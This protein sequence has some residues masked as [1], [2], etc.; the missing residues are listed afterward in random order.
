MTCKKV[1]NNNNDSQQMVMKSKNHLNGKKASVFQYS[2][3]EA[4]L[5]NLNPKIK[6][7]EF[8][9]IFYDSTINYNNVIYYDTSGVQVEKIN[10]INSMP[11]FTKGLEGWLIYL[12]KKL[13]SVAD[14]G[15]RTY[16]GVA[17]Y[18]TSFLVN[19][20]GRIDNVILDNAIDPQLDKYIKDVLLFS[21][22][23]KPAMHN[24]RII[25]YQHV[26]PI[27]LVLNPNQASQ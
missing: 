14:F 10:H 23:W 9:S 13:Y 12:E 2:N 1:I 27:S 16:T 17:I 26:Q 18:V 20:N 4:E 6:Q 25:P 22:K 11:E 19:L 15:A 24:N 8:E 5:T 7:D 3:E 21:P